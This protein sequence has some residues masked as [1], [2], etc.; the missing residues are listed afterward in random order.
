MEPEKLL[1]NA[2]KEAKI[3]EYLADLME[4]NCMKYGVAKWVIINTLR[5]LTSPVRAELLGDLV[6]TEMKKQD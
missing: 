1:T 6:I 5:K 4:V 2:Q 3:V